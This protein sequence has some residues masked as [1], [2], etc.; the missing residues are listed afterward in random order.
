[1]ADMLARAERS[2]LMSRIRSARNERTEGRLVALFRR[3]RIWGWRRHRLVR[4]QSS[5]AGIPRAVRPD[6]IFPARRQI[7]LVD[8]CF[9]HLCPKHARF[10]KTRA[11]FWRR[12]L[13]RN[14]QRDRLTN[15]RLRSQGWRVLRLWEH[16]LV[17]DNEARLLR[18]LLRWF[19]NSPG[20]AGH[21][22]RR[23][24]C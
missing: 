1:M 19:L 7:V 11:V 22:R 14:A 8:G 24:G 13:L 10:P 5:G 6:F 2:A 3:Y 23:S 20:S 15:Q 18:K 17:R 16:E 4:L 21:R 12:K 9:W